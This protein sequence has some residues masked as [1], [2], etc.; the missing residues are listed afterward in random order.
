VKFN[1]LS[2]LLRRNP[3]NQSLIDS[4]GQVQ[5]AAARNNV[6]HGFLV[7]NEDGVSVD[8]ITRDIKGGKYVVK[9]KPHNSVTHLRGFMDSLFEL[10]AIANVTD[11]EITEYSEAVAAD[12]R[13]HSHPPNNSSA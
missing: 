3:N 6:T 2:S 4:L 10:Q 1:V 9:S 7:R 13:A 5:A 11:Q 12:A 8:L